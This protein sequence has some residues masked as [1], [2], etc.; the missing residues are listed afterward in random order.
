VAGA[1]GKGSKPLWPVVLACNQNQV[2]AHLL[3]IL[4]DTADEVVPICGRECD[5]AEIN[6]LLTGVARVSSAQL[7]LAQPKL[8]WTW[9]HRRSTNHIVYHG[10]HPA[11][12]PLHLPL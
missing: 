10:T 6:N 12:Q 5:L 4:V 9:M 11:S 2:P 7:Q 3:F 8:S 1:R